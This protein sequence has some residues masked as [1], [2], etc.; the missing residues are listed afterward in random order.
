M[1]RF[2]EVTI[3]PNLGILLDYW[4]GLRQGRQMPSRADIDPIDMPRHLLP[5]ILLIQVSHDPLR[6][7]YRLMGTA[8]AELLGED[9]TGK[10]SDEIQLA[11]ENVRLQYVET[12]EKAAPTFYMNQYKKFDPSVGYERLLNYERVLLPLSDDDAVVHHLLGATLAKPA[13]RL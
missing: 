1:E 11:H 2:E 3:S 10:Y 4:T 13:E 6:F 9:W 7:Y 8:I 5:S 12:V